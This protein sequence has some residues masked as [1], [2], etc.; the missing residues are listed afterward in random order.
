MQDTGKTCRLC[1]A[2]EAEERL[3][4]QLIIGI[5]HPKIQE[6]LLSRDNMLTLDAAMDIART[7]ESTL[8]DMNAFQSETSLTTYQVKQRREDGKQREGRRGNC[9]NCNRQHPTGKC[10]AANSRCRPCGRHGHWKAACR[11]KSTIDAPKPSS[12]KPRR[13]RSQ[14]RSGRRDNKQTV[15]QLRVNEEGTDD[16]TFQ[17]LGF[18]GGG[19]GRNSGE[20]YFNEF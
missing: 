9:R 7:H 15:H 11:S 4:E 6:K 19:A 1:A 16:D 10:P 12:Q 18:R 14:S 13:P 3:I 2:L 20:F 5:R 8:A 17:H